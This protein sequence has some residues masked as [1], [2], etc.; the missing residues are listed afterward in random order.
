MSMT[1]HCPDCGHNFESS[2][3]NEAQAQI[4][5][6]ETQVRLLNSKASSYIDRL[7]DYEDEIRQLQVQCARLQNDKQ[8]ISK[9]A[10]ESTEDVTTPAVPEKDNKANR[11]S[12][13][14]LSSL[15]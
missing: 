2:D 12:M 15:T 10:E 7:A 5:D 6:L 9:S 11:Q 14:R 8:S 1:L 13:S 4:Q 3:A